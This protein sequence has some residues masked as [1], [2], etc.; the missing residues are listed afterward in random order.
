MDATYNVQIITLLFTFTAVQKYIYPHVSK[1]HDMIFAV[2]WELKTI[3]LSTAASLS[4]RS[5]NCGRGVV[6]VKSHW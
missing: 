4:V 5:G 6:Y 2:D 1:E 3:D